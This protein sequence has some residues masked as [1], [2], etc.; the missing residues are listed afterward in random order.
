MT[1]TQVGVIFFLKPEQDNCRE[2]CGSPDDD[3]KESKQLNYFF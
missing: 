1:L 3:S 2:L